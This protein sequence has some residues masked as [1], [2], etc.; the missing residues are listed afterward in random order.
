[1]VNGFFLGGAAE[2]VSDSRK[3]GLDDRALAADTGLRTRA[4]DI[5]EKTLQRAENQDAIKRVDDNIANTMAVVS[6]T[7]KGAIAV[8]RDPA[9]IQK[10]VAPLVES[11]KALAAKVGRDPRSLDAQVQAQLFQPT[12]METKSVEGAGKAVSQIAEENTLKA[13]GYDGLGKWKTF[14]EKVKAEGALR[15]DYLKQAAPFITIRDA[16][17]RLDTIEETGAG[18]VALVFQYMKILDPGSTVREGEFATAS[19]AA[20]VPSS[21]IATYNKLTGGGVLAPE[22]RKQIKSQAGKLYQAAA[23]Q[24]DKTTTKFGEIAKRN[25]LDDR[26]VIVDLLPAGAEKAMRTPGMI[27][28]G[29]INLSARP[30]VQNSDGS[31]STVRSMSVNVG[32]KEVLIPTVSED[33]R[34]MSKDEAVQQF[35]KTGKHLGKFDSPAA[36]TAYAKTLSAEQGQQYGIPVDI[37]PPP[38]GF[39]V[40]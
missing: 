14:D 19:N 24:H 11:A 37:P 8:G 18:D 35:K 22:A 26:N 23:N 29:N 10:A 25:R 9:A 16:K 40:R 34:I 39:V 2:G 36:A 27:E 13:A 1:M 21:I 30:V 12:T 32:G 15:D 20:G 33:G 6:E 28:R 31:I 17:N 5:Q 38:A 4:V 7:I 3:A